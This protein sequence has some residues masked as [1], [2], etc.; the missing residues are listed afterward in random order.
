[1]TR[2]NFHRPK[3]KTLSAKTAAFFSRS[4]PRKNDSVVRPDHGDSLSVRIHNDLPGLKE[5]IRALESGFYDEAVITRVHVTKGYEGPPRH[6]LH[7]RLLAAIGQLPNLQEISIQGD[8]NNWPQDLN[9]PARAIKK[10]LLD[11]RQTIRKVSFQYIQVL[12]RKGQDPDLQDSPELVD[13]FDS[14]KELQCLEQ[15]EI[16]NCSQ[17]YV[18]EKGIICRNG[19][20]FLKSVLGPLA[21]IQ[22]LTRA[23]LHHDCWDHLNPRELQQVLWNCLRLEELVLTGFSIGAYDWGW[24]VPVILQRAQNLKKLHLHHCYL[25]ADCL[26]V[27]LQLMG[28]NSPLED[29]EF[30]PSLRRHVPDTLGNLYYIGATPQ[31]IRH[32]DEDGEPT[33]KRLLCQAIPTALE[34]NTK[35]QRLR[36][37]AKGSTNLFVPVEVQQPWLDLLERGHNTSLQ[38]FGFWRDDGQ[39]FHYEDE[40]MAARFEH[41]QKLMRF[42]IGKLKGEERDQIIVDV[43]AEATEDVS[44]LVHILQQYPSLCTTA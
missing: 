38:D 29:F 17:S 9:I 11:S 26:D 30:L 16:K 18:L 10:L 23:T 13:L 1:M 19:D 31:S 22:S 8:A 4:R 37:K 32:D 34:S 12:T 28:P 36:I 6:R 2:Q 39:S 15:F 14:L 20:R 42:G 27:F 7:S 5:A 21:S 25:S 44:C 40:E 41:H 43:L 24:I 3:V 33:R 35:L